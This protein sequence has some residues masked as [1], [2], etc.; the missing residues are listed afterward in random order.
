MKLG[1]LTDLREALGGRA[2]DGRLTV[3]ATYATALKRAAGV[4]GT[5]LFD[6]DSVVR[7]RKQHPRFK[8]ADVYGARSAAPQSPEAKEPSRKSLCKKIATECADEVMEALQ[9]K[10]TAGHDDAARSAIFTSVF[11]SASAL[12]ESPHSVRA[13]SQVVGAEP[14]V[15]LVD[16]S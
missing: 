2:P 14:L 9:G 11:A 3:G 4:G 6:I 15:S 13:P 16:E 10:L 7:W 5:R 12:I 8:I 1:S